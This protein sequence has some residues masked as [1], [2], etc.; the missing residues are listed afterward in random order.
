MEE[1][2]INT[3]KFETLFIEAIQR[4]LDRSWMKKRE[5]IKVKILYIIPI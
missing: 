5:S 1:R 4:L 2:K 3:E